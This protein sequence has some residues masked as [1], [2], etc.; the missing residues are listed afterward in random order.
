M[1]IAR[2]H[3]HLAAHVLVHA[4]LGTVTAYKVRVHFAPGAGPLLLASSQLYHGFTT[5]L[6]KANLGGSTVDDFKGSWNYKDL[7]K[8][9]DK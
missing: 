1:T 7:Q 9:S 5:Q 2:G 6:A 3:T 4:V 8:A